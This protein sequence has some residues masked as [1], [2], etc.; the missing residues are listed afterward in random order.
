VNF[1]PPKYGVDFSLES[2]L[3]GVGEG[4]AGAGAGDEPKK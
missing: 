4:G 2:G 3:V 1:D